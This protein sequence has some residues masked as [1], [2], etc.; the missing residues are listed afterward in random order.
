[1]KWFF[2][3]IAGL[4]IAGGIGA[5]EVE[6]EPRKFEL[7]PDHVT[8][9]FLVHHIGFAKTLGVFRKASGTVVFDADGPVLKSADVS[10]QTASVDTG[11]RARDKH[12]RSAD[13]LASRKHPTMRFVLTGSEKRNGRKGIITGNLTLRGQTRPVALTVTLNK[14]GAYPFGDKH[15]VV[16]ISA[17]GTIRRSKWGM[18][19]AVKNG[20]VGDKVEI[21][22]EAELMH[23]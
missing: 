7:D 10:V 16:G 21:I 23:R 2:P 19:Y 3:T 20:L 4:M 13:F 6:A 5:G 11:H 1:M 14:A 17:R 22:I 15:D 8:I 18:T 9:A 12:L